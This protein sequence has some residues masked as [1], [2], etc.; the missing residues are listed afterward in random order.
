MLIAML[1]RRTLSGRN[2]EMIVDGAA[3]DSSWSLTRLVELMA[4]TRFLE[5]AISVYVA[6]SVLFSLRAAWV[7]RA[8]VGFRVAGVFL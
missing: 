6:I 8:M 4:V 3:A 2:M 1:D 7:P 5:L